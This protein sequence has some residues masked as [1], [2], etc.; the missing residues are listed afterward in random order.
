MQGECLQYSPTTTIY[1][2]TD[3]ENIRNRGGIVK[4]LNMKVS[5]FLHIQKQR[6]PEDKKMNSIDIAELANNHNMNTNK[7]MLLHFFTCTLW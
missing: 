2:H 4:L 5:M 7:I 1:L 3:H 6:L